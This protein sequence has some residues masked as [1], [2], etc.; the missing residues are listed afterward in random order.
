MEKRIFEADDFPPEYVRYRDEGC[1]LSDSCLECPL[2]RCRYDE[3]GWRRREAMKRRDREVMRMRKSS[4]KSAR[5]LARM[6]GIS[7]RTV[8][9]ITRR[10]QDE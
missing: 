9:R 6:F 8:H 1:D 4:G 2:P 3:P 5:E 10:S 7:V